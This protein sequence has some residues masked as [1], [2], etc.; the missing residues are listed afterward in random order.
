MIDREVLKPKNYDIPN[1][2]ESTA[3]DGYQNIVHNINFNGIEDP[4]DYFG[5][6]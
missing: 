1:L 4:L 6:F 2:S 5:N 3:T